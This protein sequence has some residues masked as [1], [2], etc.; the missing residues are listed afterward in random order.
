MY[1]DMIPDLI[2]DLITNLTP[3]LIPDSIF[4]VHRYHPEL[5][6]GLDY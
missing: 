5:D 6:L 4:N 2:P 1:M 3:D